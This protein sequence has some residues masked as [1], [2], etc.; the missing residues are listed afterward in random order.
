MYVVAFSVGFQLHYLNATVYYLPETTGWGSTLGGL[1]TAL[2]PPQAQVDD[3]SF[4]VRTN[5]FGFGAMQF[6]LVVFLLRFGRWTSFQRRLSNFVRHLRR[7]RAAAS[8]LQNSAGLTDSCA[9]AASRP[10][11]GKCGARFFGAGIVATRHRLPLAHYSTTHT[12]P[13]TF[14]LKPCGMWSTRNP[15]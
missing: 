9:R 1:P 11:S 15:A 7:R 5:Q 6:T 2:W 3:S 8:I 12:N 4:G 10:K 13:C 14:G